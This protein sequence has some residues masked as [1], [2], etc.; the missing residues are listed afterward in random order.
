MEDGRDFQTVPQMEQIV[1]TLQSDEV[2]NLY[3]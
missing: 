1:A 3:L 2:Q